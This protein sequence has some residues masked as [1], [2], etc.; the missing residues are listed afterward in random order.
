MLA[1]KKILL[2][3]CGSIAAYKAAFFVR[4]LIKEGA[5]VKVVMT[6]S[7]K[8]FITPLT[9]ATLSK[10][11][12]YSGFI[13]ND[14]GEWVNH[15]ELGLWADLMIV[16]PLSANT[17]A[18]MANGLSDNLL[19]AVY[20]SARCPVMVSPAM[21]LDMY[22]HPTTKENL[23]KLT[24]YGNIVIEAEDGELASGLH[25]VGR[26]AEPEHLLE[27]VQHHFKKKETLKGKRVLITSGPT[28]EAFD[29]VRYI[30]NHS[31]G[32][33]GRSIALACAQRG[34]SVDFISGPVQHLPHHPAIHIQHITSAEELY[35]AAKKSFEAADI[36]IFTA[37]VV[38]YRPKEKAD[39]KLK[40]Q[41]DNLELTL[42]PNPDIALELGKMKKNG[43]VTVGFALETDNETENARAKLKK[44]NLD[45]I[46]LNSLNHEGAGFSH[47][48][49]KVT[50]FKKDNNQISFELK[51]K[52]QVAEDLLDV[53]ENM[54]Q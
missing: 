53:L 44:K 31:T 10:N 15:V 7:A 19:T 32:K 34:A 39:S 6:T 35:E 14:Q 13:K 41:K 8:D 43:Q 51:S 20:L 18:K 36:A 30:S 28:H 48:T 33:M 26:M 16:A 12:V 3:V 1:G 17:L 5:E 49:N 38:D 40:K 9:L 25:G 46:V 24:E 11:P 42:V 47:D 23:R 50:I 52:D 22:Q 37:A 21:D 45:M 29:P 54:D 2:A 4:L 27:A